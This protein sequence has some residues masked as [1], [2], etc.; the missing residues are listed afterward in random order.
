MRI[1]RA[2][3]LAALVL[4]TAGMRRTPAL[5]ETGIMGSPLGTRF[6]VRCPGDS[7]PVADGVEHG[8]RIHRLRIKCQQVASNGTLGTVVDA[9][10]DAGSPYSL[11]RYGTE[12]AV[13]VSG[14][15]AASESKG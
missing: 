13:K 14:A 6:D 12:S 7:V 2:V 11:D 10:R 9:S 8:A 1:V 15:H 5:D 4:V 3:T